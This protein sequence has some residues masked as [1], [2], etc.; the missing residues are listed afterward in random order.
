MASFYVIETKVGT[1]PWSDDQVLPN[2]TVNLFKSP[3][4]AWLAVEDVLKG[5]ESDS[6]VQ[7]RV[8]IYAGPEDDERIVGYYE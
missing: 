5:F 1:D 7:F 6:P 8:A 3:D 2:S 4:D